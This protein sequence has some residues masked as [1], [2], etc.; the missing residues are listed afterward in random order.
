MAMRTLLNRLPNTPNPACFRPGKGHINK[1]RDPELAIE[2]MQESIVAGLAELQGRHM[3][4]SLGD[5]APTLFEPVPGRCLFNMADLLDYDQVKDDPDLLLWQPFFNLALRPSDDYPAALSSITPRM[6]LALSGYR[7]AEMVAVARHLADQGT[8]PVRLN[9]PDTYAFFR[10]LP[11]GGGHDSRLDL[12]AEPAAVPRN[13]RRTPAQHSVIVQDAL[14][15]YDEEDN[16]IKGLP[17]TLLERLPLETDLAPTMRETF[18]QAVDLLKR[19]AGRA[20]R[21]GRKTAS[22][23]FK[24]VWQ[25]A[26]DRDLVP[27]ESQVVDHYLTGTW[28]FHLLHGEELSTQDHLIEALTRCM[29]QVLYRSAMWRYQQ[30]HIVLAVALI[31]GI[32]PA[33]MAR[34][35]LALYQRT[36][37]GFLAEN[38]FDTLAETIRAF[39]APKSPAA[40]AHRAELIDEL[41]LLQADFLA[42][43]DNLN[44]ATGIEV[45]QAVSAHGLPAWGVGEVEDDED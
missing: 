36:G 27:L 40:Q 20:E 4:P 13:S 1:Q 38:H 11:Y 42:A 5:G 16:P 34:A 29:V 2:A 7:V 25:A 35:N 33:C 9:A 23:Y 24:R 32:S 43:Q 41:Q 28:R 22:A 8:L 14:H 37:L 21:L 39:P 26:I 30:P 19:L 15:E 12:F 18:T 31:S 17:A 10:P 3:P 6:A 45:H 44:P